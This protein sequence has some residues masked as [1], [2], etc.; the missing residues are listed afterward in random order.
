MP[1]SPERRE[2]GVGWMERLGAALAAPRLALAR[3]ET[4]GGAG[5]APADQ[6][7]LILAGFMASRLERLG[8]AGWLAIDGAGVDGVHMLLADLSRALMT[9]LLFVVVGGFTVTLAAGRRRSLA[10]DFDLAC[11]AAVPIAAIPS[12]MALAAR[13][14]MSSPALVEAASW[15]SYLWSAA[16]LVL[17]AQ[18]ARRRP[19]QPAREPS[20]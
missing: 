17:A 8:R 14:G 4:A 15:A 16:I 19:G 9:P 1:R 2:T 10:A 18:Q 12:L 3:S 20:R 11:I 5:R 6:A 13:L 7:V